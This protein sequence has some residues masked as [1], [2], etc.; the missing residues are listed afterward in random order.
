MRVWIM[1]KWISCL[2][3]NFNLQQ[4]RWAAG[5]S[6][7][8][9]P[10]A[11]ESTV[12]WRRHK[13]CDTFEH[14]HCRVQSLCGFSSFSQEEWVKGEGKEGKRRRNKE[15][16]GGATRD[17][18]NN[19]KLTGSEWL[20]ECLALVLVPVHLSSFPLWACSDPHCSSSIMKTTA[21]QHTHT[22]TI[23]QCKLI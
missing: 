19:M 14:F 7:R 21:D 17:T 13:K 1:G 8:A 2:T 15:G 6:L 10:P 16:R 3:R 4:H 11:V 9:S 5:L 12:K 22:H 23:I 18:I 20:E